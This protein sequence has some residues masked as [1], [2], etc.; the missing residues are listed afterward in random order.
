AKPIIT[1]FHTGWSWCAC[2]DKYISVND[3]LANTLYGP[4]LHAHVSYLKFKMGLTLGK[5]QKLIDEQ[6]GL[7]IS[8]GHLSE[9]ISRT[10]D[11]LQP[12]WDDLKTS[13]R[14][15]SHLHADETGWRIDGDNGWL[16]SFAN[17]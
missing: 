9:M 6:F 10:A 4:R 2:C 3:K 12:A 13:L 11:K 1:T 17:E 5:I 8:T 7:W 16:W 14:D 15:Q